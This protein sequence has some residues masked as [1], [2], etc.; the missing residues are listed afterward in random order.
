MN[1]NDKLE[2]AV[3][4]AAKAIY[5]RLPL[6]QGLTEKPNWVENGNSLKQDDARIYARAA[7]LAADAILHPPAPAPSEPAEAVGTLTVRR[8]RGSD[9]M[10]NHDFDLHATLPDGSY[11]L[12]LRQTEPAPA[13]SEPDEAVGYL[14]IGAGGYIDI[15][16]DLTDAQLSAMP[17]G[18]HM[19]GIIGTY[20]VDGYTRPQTE[21]AQ[22]VGGD[23][24]KQLANR[25]VPF[26]M[27]K[28]I[29]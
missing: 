2:Q 1:S 8:Y 15:G 6:T 26:L 25:A 20:G 29:D 14:D 3:E 27:D 28:E 10:V 4:A 18:R 22:A 24:L 11:Q 13:T 19:L 17:K 12:Y 21:L 23:A 9:A 5:D 16:S 7:I